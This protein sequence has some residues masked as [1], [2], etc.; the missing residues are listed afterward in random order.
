LYKSCEKNLKAFISTIKNK[1]IVFCGA[2]L[3]A[4]ISMVAVVHFPELK[5]RIRHVTFGL[6]PT[7]NSNFIK[8]YLKVTK[9]GTHFMIS[10]DPITMMQYKKIARIFGYDI[11][12]KGVRILNPVGIRLIHHTM[13]E[14][15]QILLGSKEIYKKMLIKNGLN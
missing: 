1:N 13:N 9:K 5:S 8:E 2:S 7:G 3:G 14:Y 6:P 10:N 11:I 4:A 12:S 15:I